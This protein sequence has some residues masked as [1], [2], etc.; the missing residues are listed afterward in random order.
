MY[1]MLIT[2]CKLLKMHT[3]QGKDRKDHLFIVINVIIV[4]ISVV[5]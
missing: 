1:M 2:R 5:N 4:F 3:L